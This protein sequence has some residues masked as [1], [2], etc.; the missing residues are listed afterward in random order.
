MGHGGLDFLVLLGPIAMGRLDAV[1]APVVVVALLAAASRRRVAAAALTAAA[2]IKVA[3]GVLLIP[4]VVMVRRPV[5]DVVVPA[6]LVCAEVVGAVGAGGG[7]RF[8]ASFLT[9]Q[10]SRGLQVESVVASPW[11][12][13]ALVRDD[14]RVVLN[15]ELS[16]WKIV[17]HGTATAARVLD[18]ALPLAVAGLALLIWRARYLR[19]SDRLI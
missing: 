4:L 13:A 11:T 18:V 1:V 15:A 5:R 3:P 2:W 9:A 8:V 14:I 16:T 6:P 12:L 17:G 10:D 7:L 19:A